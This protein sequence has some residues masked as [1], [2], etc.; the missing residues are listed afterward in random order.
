MRPI[1]NYNGWRVL[2]FAGR[3]PV[4]NLIEWKIKERFK[5]KSLSA[6][7]PLRDSLGTITD[8]VFKK[9]KLGF[10]VIS[11]LKSLPFFL[12]FFYSS[13][14]ISRPQ[15]AFGAPL[16][17]A[18]FVAFICFPSPDSSFSVV[19]S[20]IYIYTCIILCRHFT[21]WLRALLGSNTY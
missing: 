6:A 3:V 8:F 20:D 16:R 10:I 9:K 18:V 12:L 14:Y 11:F 15:P 5:V 2:F 4:C 17:S 19:K 1:W 7:E 21:L 13:K